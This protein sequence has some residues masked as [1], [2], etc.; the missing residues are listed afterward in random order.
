[1]ST[2]TSNIRWGI[3]SCARV[4]RRRWIPAIRDT[5]GGTVTAIASR[6]ADKARQ[7]AQEQQIPTSYG[8][9]Q[10]LLDDPDI[11]AIFIGLPNSLHHPWTIKALQAGKHVLCDKPLSINADQAQ[12]MVTTAEK[13]QLLLV[14]GFMYQFNHQHNLIRRWLDEG[15]I[16]T[17]KMVR[18]GF[19]ALFDQLDNIRFDPNLGGGALFDLG[20]YCVHAVR[21][22]VGQEPRAIRATS[23]IGDTGVDLNTLVIMEFDNQITASLDCAFNCYPRQ[24]LTIAGTKGDISSNWPFTPHEDTV[25]TLKTDSQTITTTIQPFNQYALCVELFQKRI[26]AQDFTPSPAHDSIAN[27]KVLDAIRQSAASRRQCLI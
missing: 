5:A 18:I 15:K 11:D 2:S 23:V 16:G 12:A 19:S 10:E 9:Y 6:S 4:A 8:S 22:I 27:M 25:L 14:E 1:M 24:L 20:C 7:W 3:L 26:L 21:M 17:L 13:N